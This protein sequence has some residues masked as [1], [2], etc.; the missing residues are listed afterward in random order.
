VLHWRSC[1]GDFQCAAARVPLDYRHPL[2]Q[3]IS[4]A[5]MRHRATGPGRRLGSLF[6]NQGGPAVQLDTFPQAYQQIPATVRA[7]YDVVSFDP[8]GYG[9]S[10]AISCFAT[11]TD[12]NH[13]LS[14]LALFPIGH[15]QQQVWE[16]IAARF[17]ARC[18][19]HNGALLAHDS[20]QDVARDMD[21][22]RQAVG[23][24]VLN[25]YGESYGTGLG[26]IYANLF[27]TRTGRM[28][29]DG[30]IDLAEWTQHG[31]LPGNL[32]D[33][34]DVSDERTMAAFLNF[35]GK[36]GTSACAFAAGSPAKTTAKWN[37]LLRRLRRHPSAAGSP[38]QLWTYAD[39]IV[40]FPEYQFSAWPVDAEFLQQLWL[41]SAPGHQIPPGTPPLHPLAGVRLE[42]IISTI[43]SDVPSPRNPAAYV[44]AAR[45]AYAR[46]GGF[47]LAF[48]WQ[49]APCARWP[50]E[51]AADRYPGPWNAPT[52]S[53]ILVIG[54]TT[55]PATPYHNSVIMTRDL[56]HA[57][58]LTVHGY[59]HTVIGNP[60]TCAANYAVQ[61]LITGALPPA[62]T[63]CKQNA[64]PFGVTGS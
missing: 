28:I 38:L 32:R 42:Q 31:G 16:G 43:C 18:A 29:F 34:A 17:D 15:R 11:Q 21:L 60:S 19:S 55:D 8:R 59:G 51:A 61:Y 53:T 57:R 44:R 62:G 45:V 63:V 46:S 54:I 39:V 7:R 30:N 6:F 50:K 25:Y 64:T 36:A 2:G 49:Y 35:C 26:A 12:E 40:E 23:D 47:G 5:V 14:H 4:I 20:T 37:T 13:F 27:P 24:P 9:R 48:A 1:A 33:R 52:A 56:A 41:N 58:L 22:L 10:T 3:T